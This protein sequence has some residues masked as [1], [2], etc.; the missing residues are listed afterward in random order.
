MGDLPQNIQLAFVPEGL[1]V[2][3][4]LVQLLEDNELTLFL[5]FK[6]YNTIMKLCWGKRKKALSLDTN[7][8]QMGEVI[9]K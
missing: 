7:N 2:C 5:F 3:S 8:Q 9:I 6:V 1:T 4:L